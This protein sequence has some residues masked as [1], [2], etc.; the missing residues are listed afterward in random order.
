LI[1]LPNIQSE[2][3]EVQLKWELQRYYVFGAFVPPGRHSIIIKAQN[4]SSYVVRNM[5]VYPVTR[6]YNDPI[7]LVDRE[8]L[9]A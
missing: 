7:A 9:R 2:Y 1:N 3:N 8:T 4:T 5:I 6:D